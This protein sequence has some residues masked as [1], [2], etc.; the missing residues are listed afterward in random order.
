MYIT[1]NKNSSPEKDQV[2]LMESYRNAYGNPRRRIVKK[3]GKL[4]DLENKDPSIL[5]KLKDEAKMYSS[6]IEN[7]IV[8][9]NINLSEKNGITEADKNYGVFF[10][11]NLSFPWNK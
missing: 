11:I 5:D 4:I 9:M 1:I 8:T 2:Y 3:Y 6:T 7:S 10:I